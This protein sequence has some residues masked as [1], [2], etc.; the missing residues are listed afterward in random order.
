VLFSARTSVF[1]F[2]SLSVIQN[3]YSFPSALTIPCILRSAREDAGAPFIAPPFVLNPS[4]V[5][6]NPVPLHLLT[7]I[8]YP[9]PIVQTT[10]AVMVS[11]E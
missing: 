4:F 9:S 10:N 2:A 7:S 11:R 1:L 6:A 3:Y 8:P 5:I